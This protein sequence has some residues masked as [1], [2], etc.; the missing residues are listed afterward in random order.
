M[1]LAMRNPIVLGTHRKRLVPVLVTYSI[2][3]TVA[4]LIGLQLQMWLWIAGYLFDT[5]SVPRDLL[6]T[7][8]LMSNTF[9][10]LSIITLFALRM[11]LNGEPCFFAV[12]RQMDCPGVEAFEAR[13]PSSIVQRIWFACSTTGLTAYGL[14]VAPHVLLHCS[15]TDLTAL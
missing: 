5:S 3:L 4:V 11:C 14:H 6:A 8:S 1:L 2:V 13:P 7:T 12:L 10:L 15:T 9:C